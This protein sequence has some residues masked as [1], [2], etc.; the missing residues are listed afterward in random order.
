MAM[1]TWRNV[2][3]PDFRTSLEG[4]QTFSKLLD[5]AFR[6]ANEGINTFDASLDEKANKAVMAAAMRERDPEAYQ[7][8]LASGQFLEGVDAD[9]VSAQTYAALNSQ[10][11]SLLNQATQAQQL[12]DMKYASDQGKAFDQLGDEYQQIESLRRTGT[13]EANAEADRLMASL[14]PQ[15]GA[16]G[17]RNTIGLIKGLND[18]ELFGVDLTGR[19][20]EQTL[21][22]NRDRRDETRLG[23]EG[24]RVGFERSRLEMDRGRYNWEVSDRNDIKAGQAAFMAMQGRSMDRETAL[25]AF[26]S[27]EFANLTPGA[28]M[29]ALQQ[30]NNSWGNIYTPEQLG[31]AAGFSPTVA[32]ANIGAGPSDPTRVMNYQARAAGFSAV[33]DSVRTL[34]D[35]SDF[36]LQVNSAGVD[37]SAMGTYQIVG[38]T[39]RDYGPRVFGKNWRNIEFNQEN[40]D[41]LA[42]A[43]FNDNRGSADALRRQWVSLSP[44]EAERVRR[45]PWEQAR[46]VIAAKE[47][48][49]SAQQ[50]RGGSPAS[51]ATGAQLRAG[52][53]GVNKVPATTLLTAAGNNTDPYD[54]IKSL[55]TGRFAGV[56]PAILNEGLDD[57]MERS[58]TKDGRY[59]INRAQAAEILKSSLVP[60]KGG[61]SIF[62]N[63]IVTKD[64]WRV[65]YN[66]INQEIKRARTGGLSADLDREQGRQS[67]M[68][69]LNAAQ[70]KLVFAR[71]AYQSALMRISTQ[72]GLRA[73]LPG[74]QARMQAAQAA[75]DQ[76][77]N[78]VESR[79]TP[80]RDVP[81]SSNSGLGFWDQMK[82]LVTLRRE[83]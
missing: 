28:K 66:K 19:R 63:Q 6:G 76:V 24:E 25:S 77:S 80:N 41:K 44:A 59:T 20:Q 38:Q 61:F 35:A 21:A 82:N 42:Q 15:L 56:S 14:R 50:V 36:A 78:Q 34:G 72:P 9:R 49:A 3:A 58:K 52:Q 54:V 27:P 1:L 32:G 57:V 33:P 48:G 64:G 70:T 74:L 37:S 40:Q 81:A 31:A 5:N 18:S 51:I 22:A 17:I 2:D 71:Q 29:Y 55:S 62:G 7:A 23:Y 65:D 75:Y 69:N 16:A 13:P 43:I 46:Q 8:A 12:G 67:D 26:N 45:M 47:S 83:N 68:Q 39:M 73:E 11:S 60:N 30:L 4:Y 53:E 79:N 10:A